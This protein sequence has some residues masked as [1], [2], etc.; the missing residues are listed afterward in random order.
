LNSIQES[1]WRNGRFAARSRRHDADLSFHVLRSI[2]FPPR[3]YELA[4]HLALEAGLAPWMIA[5]VCADLRPLIGETVARGGHIRVGLED[6]PGTRRIA[7]NL[8][9]PRHQWRI[10]LRG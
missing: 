2:G 8:Q 10:S 5:G 4:A 6:A 7:L 3:P 9:R 1:R